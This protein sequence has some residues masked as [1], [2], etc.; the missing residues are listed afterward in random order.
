MS[1]HFHL[2]VETPAGNLGRFMQGVLTGY[3]VYFNRA[4]REHGHVTQGRY[5][6][7]L[8]QGAGKVATGRC[9]VEREEERDSR[10]N[11]VR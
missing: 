6:A 7:R 2:V 10:L 8:V 3:G 4:H 5:G 9:R 11:P 1:N